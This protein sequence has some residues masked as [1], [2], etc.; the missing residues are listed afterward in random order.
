MAEVVFKHQPPDS[1]SLC[2]SFLLDSGRKVLL[3]ES[4]IW[5]L[6]L[7]QLRNH[8]ESSGPHFF[9]FQMKQAGFC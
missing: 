3:G 4:S 1:K 9:L 6:H 5:S 7:C 8:Q 2:H